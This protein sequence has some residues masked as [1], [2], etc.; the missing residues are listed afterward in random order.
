MQSF[1]R[2]KP[3]RLEEQN[4]QNDLQDF[5]AIPDLPAGAYANIFRG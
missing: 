1:L 2:Q 3:Y 4:N 5:E